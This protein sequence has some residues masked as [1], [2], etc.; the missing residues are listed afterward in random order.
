[1]VSTPVVHRPPR[2]GDRRGGARGSAPRDA[3]TGGRSC[4]RQN[5]QAASEVL[6][7]VVFD[8][9]LG[10]QAH[11]PAGPRAHQLELLSPEVSAIAPFRRC[12]ARKDGDRRFQPAAA[13]GPCAPLAERTRAS[14]GQVP[15]E[16][17]RCRAD[18]R[19]RA[20]PIRSRRVARRAFWASASNAS[21]RTAGPSFFAR[22][23]RR[24]GLRADVGE[25]RDTRSNASRSTRTV[26]PSK[27]IPHPPH[28]PRENRRVA[29]SPSI[30]SSA[31]WDTR[32][33]RRVR[34][35]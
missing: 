7:H 26:A 19:D 5:L 22:G 23:G 8:I 35:R 9:S 29:P 10:W 31:N 6:P 15:D 25:R 27:A 18:A 17:Q 13:R 34:D 24:E 16:P 21:A 4:P 33:G 11:M 3:S 12:A 1:M 30:E 2:L 14:R 20:P 28:A 32:Y